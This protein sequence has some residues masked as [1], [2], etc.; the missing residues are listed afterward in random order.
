MANDACAVAVPLTAAG[1][2]L[3]GLRTGTPVAVG[4]GDDFA[5]VLGAG[6]TRPGTLV[7]AIG[8]AEVVGILPAS[9]VLEYQ[10]GDEQ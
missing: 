9:P 3:T 6:V 4:T 5:N 7:C 8:T 10:A 1:A 2:A